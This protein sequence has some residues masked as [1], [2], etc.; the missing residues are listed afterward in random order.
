MHQF[1]GDNVQNEMKILI[2]IENNLMKMMHY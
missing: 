1:H 2:L